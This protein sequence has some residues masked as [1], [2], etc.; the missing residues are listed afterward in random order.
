MRIR[1]RRLVARRVAG[2]SCSLLGR[3]WARSPGRG[4][5][6]RTRAVR[7]RAVPGARDLG[8]RL[9]LRPGVP[10][11]A[12]RAAGGHRGVGRRHGQA[13][14]EDALPPGRPG[15]HPLR[16]LHRRPR[17]SSAT[18]CAARTG[19]ACRSSPG[20]CRTSPT[21]TATC[22]TSGRCTSSAAAGERF[23]GIALDIE[24]TTRREG[25]REAQRRAARARR[26]APA[27]WSPTM[28]LG[29]IVLEPVLLEDVNPKYWPDFPWK[30]LRPFVRRL[31]ADELLDEP[32]R[33]RP[34]GRTAF[35][36]TSENIRRVRTNLG[37]RNAVVHVIGGIADQTTP[38]T[39]TAS[40]TPPSAAAPS[41][42]PSTTTSPPAAAPGP[43]CVAEHDRRER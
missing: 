4:V 39:P 28:P 35:R 36:Y 3:P 10:G 31:A 6:R 11:L 24:W 8:R 27:S 18:S 34:G 1:T 21:W 33:R 22:A 32:H 40:S 30:K 41:A 15:R 19:T 14:R 25:H 7:S 5:G 29:A 9:R 23:D 38:A 2:R 17:R 43:G 12:G 26:A 13:R 20:T 42:G 37:D 16:G